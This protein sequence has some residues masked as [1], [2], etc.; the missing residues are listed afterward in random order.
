MMLTVCRVQNDLMGWTPNMHIGHAHHT[1]RKIDLWAGQYKDFDETIIQLRSQME[2]DIMPKVNWDQMIDSLFI[3]R[4][5]EFQ[6]SPDYWK[7][8]DPNSP[9][10]VDFWAAF[11]RVIS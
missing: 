4:P 1:R 5:D 11:V 7:S 8:L 10:W 6:G 2:E 9:E 3:G